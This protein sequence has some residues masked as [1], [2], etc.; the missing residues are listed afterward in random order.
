MR[1][2]SAAGALRATTRTLF[3]LARPPHMLPLDPAFGS[4]IRAAREAARLSQARLARSCGISLR[5][6][7]AIERGANFTV[8][9]LVAISRALPT[10]P[11]PGAAPSLRPRKVSY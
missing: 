9:V 1:L 7:V 2:I 6:L 8:A 3:L 5:H 4:A 11:V 10:L